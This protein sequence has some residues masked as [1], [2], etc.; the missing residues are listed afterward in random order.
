VGGINGG[1]ANK[2]VEE[3]DSHKKC[4]N[5]GYVSIVHHQ[6][7]AGPRFQPHP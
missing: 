5:R 6:R 1:S 7:A 3:P 4:L 2:A